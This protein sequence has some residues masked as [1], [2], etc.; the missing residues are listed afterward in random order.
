M[1]TTPITET[2]STGYGLMPLVQVLPLPCGN[3]IVLSSNQNEYSTTYAL[4]FLLNIELDDTDIDTVT[5]Y[6]DDDNYTVA[7][8]PLWLPQSFGM[9]FEGSLALLMPVGEYGHY[10]GADGQGAFDGGRVIHYR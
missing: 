7:E 2:A 3:I 10:S 8:N 1:H 4:G 9:A 5:A 6:Y